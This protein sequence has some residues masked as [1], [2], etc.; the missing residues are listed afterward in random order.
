MSKK[1]KNRFVEDFVMIS[2]TPLMTFC[3]DALMSEK[4]FGRAS[5]DDNYRASARIL[6]R[7]SQHL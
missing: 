7:T 3:H 5:Q 4:Q 1:M 6:F 2:F